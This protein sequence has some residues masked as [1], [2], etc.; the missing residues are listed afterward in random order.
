MDRQLSDYLDQ[1]ERRLRALPAGERADIILEIR[2]ELQELEA[3]GAVPEDILARLGDARSLAAAYLGEA[4]VKRPGFSLSRLGAVAA[5]WGLAGLGGVFVLPITSTLA[6]GLL[7][8][9]VLAL[10]AGLAKFLASLIGIDL[11]FIMFQ[12]GGY[13]APPATAFKLSIVAGA[14]LLL[15]GQGLWRFTVWLVRRIGQ[16][17]SSLRAER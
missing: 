3:Q 17:Y 10:A 5:F 12:I 6:A 16:Q 13:T 11:P 2:S 8:G 7:L 14:L 1:V 9:G 4:I 15:A